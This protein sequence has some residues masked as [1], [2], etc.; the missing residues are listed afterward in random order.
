MFN[1]YKNWR[2]D[3]FIW[4]YVKSCKTCVFSF[5]GNKG[6]FWKTQ[7]NIF[8]NVSCIFCCMFLR[9]LRKDLLLRLDKIVYQFIFFVILDQ[10]LHFYRIAFSLNVLKCNTVKHS[11]KTNTLL[12]VAYF[13][14]NIWEGPYSWFLTKHF[15]ILL[16]Y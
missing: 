2:T 10:L 8:C 15:T 7:S 13:T 1:I 16:L 5:T 14:S 3:K 9:G 12:F 11:I 4:N 6:V